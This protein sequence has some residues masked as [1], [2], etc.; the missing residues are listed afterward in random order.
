MKATIEFELPQSFDLKIDNDA[1]A[2]LLRDLI[3]GEAL[4]WKKVDD[5]NV[6][7]SAAS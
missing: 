5:L 6:K 4:D 2:E 1:W 7:V 3:V